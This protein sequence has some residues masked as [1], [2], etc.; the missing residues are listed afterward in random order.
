MQDS[1][2]FKMKVTSHNAAELLPWN[3]QETV[4]TVEEAA[5]PVEE[6]APEVFH[7]HQKECSRYPLEGATSSPVLLPLDVG[8][9][10]HQL[11][12]GGTG[13]RRC[14]SRRLRGCRMSTYEHKMQL[15]RTHAHQW[16]KDA[17][18]NF[19]FSHGDLV[20][21]DQLA[22]RGDRGCATYCPD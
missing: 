19:I 20:S 2:Y 17:V 10:L 5:L 13:P 4:G 3:S 6:L 9:I 21:I 15:T 8:H 12:G 1:C 11:D 18:R 16:H 14:R 7:C 22:G